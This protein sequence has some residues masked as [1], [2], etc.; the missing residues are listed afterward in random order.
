MRIGAELPEADP[1][2]V[3][4]SQRCV[5]FCTYFIN[6]WPPGPPF[7]QIK[8]RRT[9]FKSVTGQL[10]CAWFLSQVNDIGFCPLNCSCS[11]AA[12]RQRPSSPGHHMTN[13]V[14][15]RHLVK[16]EQSGVTCRN[17]RIS[18]LDWLSDDTFPLNVTHL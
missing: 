14:R 1:V 12:K 2:S 13:D 16:M 15:P 10:L 8:G 6:F 18:D 11:E 3:S 7:L 9:W 5:Q 17:R 4:E